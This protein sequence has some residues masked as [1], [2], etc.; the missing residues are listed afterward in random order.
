MRLY[1]RVKQAGEADPKQT[2]GV[3]GV[4]LKYNLPFTICQ[5]STSQEEAGMASGALSS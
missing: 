2:R 5:E 4:C 3:Y 1:Q